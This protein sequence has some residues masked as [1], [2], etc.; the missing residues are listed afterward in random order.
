MRG[1]PSEY[2][3]AIAVHVG[4]VKEALRSFAMG[5]LPHGWHFLPRIL[6]TTNVRRIFTCH[7]ENEN[8]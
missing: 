5:S 2:N 1:S 3:Y 4:I 6:R 7:F 8:G